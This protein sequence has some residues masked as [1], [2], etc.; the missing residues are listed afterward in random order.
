MAGALIKNLRHRY[1][2]WRNIYSLAQ[3]FDVLLE[4]GVTAKYVEGMEFGEHTT[5]QSGAYLYGSRSGK[6]FRVGRNTVISMGCVVLGEGGVEIGDYVHLGP[7]VVVTTQLGDSKSDPCVPEPVLKY[8]PVRIG[9]GAW[10]GAGSIIMPGTD[11]GPR[12][13]VAPAAV[14][15][16]KFPEGAKLSGNPARMQKR[17]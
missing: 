7:R 9:A 16:G 3:R 10:I 5:V 12:T 11:L 4:Q 8:L 2:L 1:K 17:F 6:P 13:I 15:F 14:V